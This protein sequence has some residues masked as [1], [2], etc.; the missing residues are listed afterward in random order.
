MEF[1]GIRAQ[2]EALKDRIEPAALSALSQGDYIL[3]A[4][5]GKLEHEL[6]SYAGRRHCVT[7]GNGT[8]AL[9]L[10]M[11]LQGIGAG[12]GVLMP[13][14]TCFAPAAAVLARAAVPILV[15]ID[16]DTF[17]MSPKSLEDAIGDSMA[18][19]CTLPKAAIAIDMFGL[20]ADFH[21][22]W[23]IAKRHGLALIEDAA[24]GLGGSLGGR[25][26]CSFGDLAITSF[27]PGKPLSCA[28]DGGAVFTDSDEDASALRSL[29][30]F[31]STCE[32]RYVNVR[33]GVNS[34]LDTVQAAILL[35]KLGPFREAEL[36]KMSSIASIYGDSL[37]DFVRV[38]R[39][40]EGFST[41][42]AQYTIMTQ[43]RSERDGLKRHLDRLGVP[44]VV[45]YPLPLHLQGAM[46]GRFAQPVS[47]EESERAAS[48][49]ISLPIHAY[50]SDCDIYAVIGAVISYYRSR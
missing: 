26:A 33:A 9:I 21:K 48:C 20:P 49:S 19:G 5:V 3:G 28:G 47:L 35:E 45:H 14:F 50:L 25:M 22:I 10:A 43:S 34:R 12:D 42:W 2:Y 37:R 36:P 44:S 39:V 41:S 23:P 16:T 31:G 6:A 32:D 46:R 13:A 24:Q 18:D 11:M 1:K 15:D 8:D 17:N 4:K 27:Y 40:P 38:P 7:C 29:R 30:T